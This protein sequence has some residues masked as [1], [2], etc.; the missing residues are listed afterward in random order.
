MVVVVGARRPCGDGD[1]DGDDEVAKG[2]KQGRMV[3]RRAF[4]MGVWKGSR[5]KRGWVVGGAD[6]EEENSE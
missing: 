1:G 6:G 3:M 5:G 2:G 4:S